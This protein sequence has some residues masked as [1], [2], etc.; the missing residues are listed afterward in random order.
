MAIDKVTPQKL[1]S[2]VDARYR[3]NTDMSDALN[4]NFGEDHKSNS[5]DSTSGG[6]L[7]VLKPT[8]S[9]TV[10][11]GSVLSS[12][13]R[14]IGSVTD[15]VLGVIFFFVWAANADEMGVWAYDRDGVLPGSSADSYVKVFT[16]SRFG[17]PA[18]GFVDGDVVHIG[19]K[20]SSDNTD[21]QDSTYSDSSD[22]S[23][24]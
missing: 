5:A 11:E 3:S 12:N 21:V 4:I 7:G 10:L 9:N 19:Q 18:L 17:F 14:V 6:D 22:K 1:N 8:P 13:S 23:C 16:S 15:D 20:Y 24:V 2:S